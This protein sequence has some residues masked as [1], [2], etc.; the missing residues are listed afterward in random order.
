MFIPDTGSRFRTRIP[1]PGVKKNTG[2]NNPDP[3]HCFGEKSIKIKILGLLFTVLVRIRTGTALFYGGVPHY[4][5]SLLLSEEFPQGAGPRFEHGT[6]LA[7]GA[8]TPFAA[9]QDHTPNLTTPNPTLLCD[10]LL[11]Y[12][13]PR[14][15]Y[16]TPQFGCGTARLSYVKKIARKKPTLL[17]N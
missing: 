14:L 12:S 4:S 17:K 1:D 2:P 10:N 11:S 15:G 7:S 8:L 13:T 9:P 16:A 5:S 3:Q 6:Y